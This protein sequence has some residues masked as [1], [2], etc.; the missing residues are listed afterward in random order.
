MLGCSMPWEGMQSVLIGWYIVPV[1]C[2]KDFDSDLSSD[3]PG[4]SGNSAWIERGTM[5]S[6]R[7]DRKKQK[8][9]CKYVLLV[10]LN[11]P[12]TH[13]KEAVILRPIPDWKERTECST[14]ALLVILESIFTQPLMFKSL[15]HN[16]K[17]LPL[18]QKI[19][20]VIV[21][22]AFYPLLGSPGLRQ[23]C[24]IQ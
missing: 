8:Q 12:S 2:Q 1:L 13:F 14:H 20:P 18:F 15:G 24:S 16:L 22:K 21:A 23:T 7:S 4:Q 6:K 5:S 3:F 10:G 9:K 17:H 11:K 19:E